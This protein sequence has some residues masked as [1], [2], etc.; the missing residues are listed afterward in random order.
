MKESKKRAVKIAT[1]Q[2]FLSPV[3]TRLYV[4]GSDNLPKKY[5]IANLPSLT[6][7]DVVFKVKIQNPIPL[8][9]NQNSYDSVLIRGLLGYFVK[10]KLLYGTAHHKHSMWFKWRGIYHIL[11]QCYTVLVHW[12][13]VITWHSLGNSGTR[14]PLP[15]HRSVRIRPQF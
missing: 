2:A 5:D 4:I 10:E 8:T 11:N 6:P 3:W 12:R 1:W 15:H 14:V 13:W 9:R 7:C